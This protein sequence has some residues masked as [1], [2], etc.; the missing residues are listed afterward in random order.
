MKCL[1]IATLDGTQSKANAEGQL[2]WAARNLISRGGVAERSG[3]RPVRIAANLTERRS[4][5]FSLKNRGEFVDVTSRM[6]ILDKN[7]TFWLILTT[8][9]SRQDDF[10][11]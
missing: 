3:E 7:W 4:E 2:L 8:Y 11:F 5:Q 1:R 6:H 10:D 9:L